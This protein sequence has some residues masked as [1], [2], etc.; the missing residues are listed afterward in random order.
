MQEKITDKS[1]Y[2]GESPFGVPEGYFDFIEDRIEER[3]RREESSGGQKLIRMLKPVLG[4]AASFALAFLLIYYPVTTILKKNYPDQY[5]SKQ[6][7]EN[8]IREEILSNSRYLDENTFYNALIN[9][10]DT[11]SFK[12]DEIITYLSEE[13][14]DYEVYAEIL[15]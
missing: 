9:Q 7:Q 10:E 11:L 2:S 4:L 6:D 3:I 1:K 13:L 15:K 14:N 12:S 8:L 5:V